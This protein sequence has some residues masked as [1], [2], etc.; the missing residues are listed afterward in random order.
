MNG[1]NY[2]I[3][4]VLIVNSDNFSLVYAKLILIIYE[5]G[6]YYFVCNKIKNFGLDSHLQ[7]NQ[8]KVHVINSYYFI[9]YED[10]FCEVPAFVHTTSTGKFVQVSDCYFLTQ[11]FI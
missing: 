1:F 2:K 3:D 4:D 7:A 5:C 8:V 11:F 9:K 10:L 6:S